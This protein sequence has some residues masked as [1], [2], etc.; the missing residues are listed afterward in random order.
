MRDHNWLRRLVRMRVQCAVL[1]AERDLQI[2]NAKASE[3]SALDRMQGR[4]VHDATM[5]LTIAR[6]AMPH[7]IFSCTNISAKRSQDPKVHECGAMRSIIAVPRTVCRARW[8]SPVLISCT[9]RLS[10]KGA[11]VARSTKA[12]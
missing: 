9:A 7:R 3:W 5:H 4:D 10:E 2:D 8:S 11:T 6:R 1:E 12:P